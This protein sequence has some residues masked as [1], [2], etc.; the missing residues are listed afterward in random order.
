MGENRLWSV[1]IV[2]KGKPESVVKVVA[3]QGVSYSQAE[4]IERGV[5]INLDTK[6]FYARIVH[7]EET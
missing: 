7:A 2:E 4:K 6:H 1:E 3:K 5:N